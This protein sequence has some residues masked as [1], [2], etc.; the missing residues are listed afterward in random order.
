MN[1]S[2]MKDIIKSGRQC[3]SAVIN[4]HLENVDKEFKPY[5]PSEGTM[6]RALQ[7]T[8]MEDHP[9]VP[10]ILRVDIIFKAQYLN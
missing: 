3:T 2:K 1:I 9:T 10:Q 4:R 6:R 8:R 7:R 5:F